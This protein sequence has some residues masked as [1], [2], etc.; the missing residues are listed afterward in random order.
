MQQI[1]NNTMSSSSRNI[2]VTQ[3]KIDLKEIIDNLKLL[4][5]SDSLN[6]TNLHDIKL[7]TQQLLK[8][9]ESKP[10]EKVKRKI[11]KKK[12]KRRRK[13]L[14]KTQHS[15]SAPQDSMDTKHN[16]ETENSNHA[17]PKCIYNTT[18]QRSRKY[19]HH[20]LRSLK[21][22]HRFLKTFELLEQLHLARGQDIPETRKFS[23]KLQQLKTIW[24]CLLQEQQA[25]QS[26]SSEQIQQQWN[27]VLF[28]D[29]EK[30]YYEG[31]PNMNY[32]LRKR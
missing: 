24:N 28:G 4:E 7:K 12:I 31:R 14:H 1:T 6:N 3:V 20:H 9:L 10:L 22:C 13:K 21:E 11:K 5:N 29:A 15:A 30:S 17:S 16:I 25:E 27:Q 19:Q 32:F 18:Q 23:C 8:G 26:N 2:A